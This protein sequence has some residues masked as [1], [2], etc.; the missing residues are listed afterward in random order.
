MIPIEKIEIGQVYQDQSHNIL[1]GQNLYYTVIKKCKNDVLLM[2]FSVLA[3]DEYPNI[4][5]N[6]SDRLFCQGN[7]IKLQRYEQGDLKC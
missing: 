7:L 6:N 2:P 3:Y 1:W 5:K 4:W